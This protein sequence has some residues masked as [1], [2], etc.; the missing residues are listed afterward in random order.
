VPRSFLTALF[1]VALCAGIAGPFRFVPI[2]RAAAEQT[3]LDAFMRQVLASRDENWKKLQQY[4]LDEREAIELTGPGGLPIW[5]ERH[6]YTWYIRDGFFVRSPVRFN[7]VEI[8][9]SGRRKAEADYLRRAQERDKRRGRRGDAAAADPPPP[10]AGPDVDAAA[11]QN[12]DALIRQTREPEFIRSAYFLRFRFEE[13]KYALVGR[14]T[15]NGLDVLRIEYY[16]ARMFRGTDRRR[17]R[18]EPSAEEK[19]RDAQFQNLMNK[20]SLVTLWVEPKAH[21]IVKY[22][23]DNVG[24]DF[25]PVQWL[26]RID[27]FKA[28]MTMGQ[29]FP[30]IWLPD[31]LD[32]LMTGTLAAG[33]FDL[34]YRLDY[35]GYRQPDVTTKVG[36]KPR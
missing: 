28:T 30:D 24:F 13:G 35:H 10:P 22:T 1:T 9:E 27:D 16:P 34:R 14:E 20:V 4:V 17:G 29:P 26:V 12:M 11:P 23:F 3:D 5:G 31:D 19:A 7:G 8:G 21:Q 15:L 18:D 32:L 2:A 6:E 33:Q 36:I 25:L